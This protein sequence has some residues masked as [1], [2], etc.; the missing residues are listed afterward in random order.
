MPS[1]SEDLT[2][3][4]LYPGPLQQVMAP[5]LLLT[6]C[7]RSSF[8]GEISWL[9]PTCLLHLAARTPPPPFHPGPLFL[10]TPQ[11][12]AARPSAAPYYAPLRYEIA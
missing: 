8:R 4:V 7:D 9:F 2:S 5:N 6:Q 3:G 12:G 11:A 10:T 1:G